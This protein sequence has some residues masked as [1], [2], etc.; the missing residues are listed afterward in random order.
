MELVCKLKGC[1]R[2]SLKK[3]S[4]LSVKDSALSTVPGGTV[5]KGSVIA[6]DTG[7]DPI[8]GCQNEPDGIA[9]PD[10][11]QDCDPYGDCDGVMSHIQDDIEDSSRFAEIQEFA[12]NLEH[13]VTAS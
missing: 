9:A 7:T 1:L 10:L 3:S 8:K 4:K 13:K 12:G 6:D 11:I 2:K 5:L